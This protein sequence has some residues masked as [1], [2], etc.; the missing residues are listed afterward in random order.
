MQIGNLVKFKPGHGRCTIAV[1]QVVDLLP[2]PTNGQDG[3]G[4][5]LRLVSPDDSEARLLAWPSQVV[6]AGQLSLI[7]T[8]AETVNTIGPNGG[9]VLERL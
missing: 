6:P 5:Q 3:M 9:L 1:W 4:Q 7:P 8:D 2:D